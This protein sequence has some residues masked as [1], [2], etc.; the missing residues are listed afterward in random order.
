MNMIKIVIEV[1]IFT[2]LIGTIATAVATGGNLTG[3]AL[4]LFGLITLVVVAGFIVYLS[5]NMGLSKK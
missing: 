3:G 5:K 1:L 2:A 4:V